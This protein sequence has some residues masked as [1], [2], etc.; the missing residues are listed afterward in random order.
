MARRAAEGNM[1]CCPGPDGGQKWQKSGAMSAPRP[2]RQ[3]PPLDEARLG[4]LAL[5]Y[6]GRFATTRARL[7]SYLKRKLRERGWSGS[8][9]PDLEALAERLAASGYI[10]DAGYGL[11]KSQALTGRGFGKRRVVQSLGVAGVADEDR[12][13]ALGHADLHAIDAALHFAERRRIGP[14]ADH[15]AVDPREREKWLGAMIR[16][17]HGFA[18]ARAIVRLPPGTE[19]DAQ[20]LADSAG[21]TIA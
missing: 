3:A 6:V 19:I 7:R 13:P 11:A 20:S 21:V 8:S 18:L 5:R 15:L 12:E 4:E 16:A 1:C 2:R 9:E 17:G 14:F 10:D